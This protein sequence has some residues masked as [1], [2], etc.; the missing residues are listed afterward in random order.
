MSMTENQPVW[1][2]AT[3]TTKIIELEKQ[4]TKLLKKKEA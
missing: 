3:L 2:N 4:V 1:D